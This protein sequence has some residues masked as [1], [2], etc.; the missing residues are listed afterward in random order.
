MDFATSL[1]PYIDL[2]PYAGAAFL[3]A[4]LLTPIAGT[5][6]HK[7]GAMD[8]P[9]S[10]RKRNDK[11]VSTRIHKEAKPRL[12][13]M[14]V[15][16]PVILIAFSQMELTTPILGILIGLIILV[17]SGVIDDIKELSGGSQIIIHFSVALLVVVTG[18]TISEIVVA[19]LN[20]NFNFFE[21]ALHFGAYTYNFIF[22]ADL[23]TIL[24]I[25]AIINA[26]NWVSG[27]DA[28]GE[29]VT[30]IASV[31]IMLLAIKLGRPEIA[32]LPAV[33]SGGVL[34]FLPYNFPPS[35][36]LGGG[37]AD[38]PYG[39]LLAVLSIV[40]GAKITTAIII[41]SVPIIDM[42]W[43]ILYRLKEHTDVPF[44]KRPFVSGRV[45]LHH[46]LMSLGFT[47]KQT[48]VIESTAMTISAVVAF[49]FGGFST[50]LIAAISVFAG[51]LVGF[52][53]ITF[54]NRKRQIEEVDKLPEPE[55][56]EPEDTQTPEERFAY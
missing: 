44:L 22:P 2:L 46:R 1:Q 41:L 27:I 29:G 35:K 34:G 25:M 43:V 5:I 6:A 51:L 17:I 19:G 3:A 15:L 47:P 13:G 14:A 32:I 12:G 16:I 18:S 4:L 36:I 31:T 8:L 26:V 33:L 49:Y 39:F 45:H 54:I 38:A 30:I 21:A 37:A 50:T 55:P 42:I 52:V 28:L 11:T 7:V 9:A 24:W 56:E 10:M 48:L 23:I 53:I 40:G 20:L